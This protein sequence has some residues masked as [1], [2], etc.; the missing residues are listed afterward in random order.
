MSKQDEKVNILI[1]FRIFYLHLQ[2]PH[3]VTF[4]RPEV[5]RR[6]GGHTNVTLCASNGKDKK[7]QN[8]T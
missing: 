7:P 2:L 5:R 4:I 8:V 3:N 6:M 1:R